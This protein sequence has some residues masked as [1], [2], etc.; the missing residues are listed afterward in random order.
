MQGLPGQVL[1]KTETETKPR[2]V[3]LSS[4]PL[5]PMTPIPSQSIAVAV[6]A[7]FFFLLLLLLFALE[8]G[9]P[10]SARL[11]GGDGVGDIF[12]PH[13]FACCKTALLLPE[14][15]DPR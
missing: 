7:C 3:Q 6:D 14:E 11:R 1:P 10:L 4:V 12:F 9:P 15:T 2:H 8:E 5:N 13:L